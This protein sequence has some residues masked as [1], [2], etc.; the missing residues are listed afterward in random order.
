VINI[1][2]LS[3]IHQRALHELYLSR[4]DPEFVVSQETTNF[5]KQ[6]QAVFREDSNTDYER[7]PHIFD[8][9][10]QIKDSDGVTRLY[11]SKPSSTLWL[12]D[13]GTKK[14]ESKNVAYI[15]SSG[16]FSGWLGPQK[17]KEITSTSLW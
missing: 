6:N 13:A 12:M 5:L 17:K 7:A 14:V 15:V 16:P 4:H 10:F 3:R 1:N 8:S 11:V 2:S 9:Y